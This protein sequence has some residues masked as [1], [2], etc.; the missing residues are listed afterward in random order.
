[1]RERAE[2][3]GGTLDVVS[4]AAAGTTVRL[5]VKAARE[6]KVQLGETQ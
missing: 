4:E 2:T 6:T 1:M 3:I 5:R